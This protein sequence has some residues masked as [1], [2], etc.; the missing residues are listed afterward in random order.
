MFRAT[1]RDTMPAACFAVVGTIVNPILFSFGCQLRPIAPLQCRAARV[2]W[3]LLTQQHSQ[4]QP[5][6]QATSS[7]CESNIGCD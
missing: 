7:Y 2:V 1:A 4:G 3:R 6:A 5:E